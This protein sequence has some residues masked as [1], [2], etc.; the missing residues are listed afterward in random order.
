MKKFVALSATA[1]INHFNV[2][3]GVVSK[4]HAMPTSS[5]STEAQETVMIDVHQP[6]NGDDAPLDPQIHQHQSPDSH[7]GG[8]GEHQVGATWWQRQTSDVESYEKYSEEDQLSNPTTRNATTDSKVGSVESYEKQVAGG[9]GSEIEAISVTT[10]GDDELDAEVDDDDAGNA[11]AHD[12][13][14]KQLDDNNNDFDWNLNTNVAALR[15]K[16]SPEERVVH[17]DSIFFPT[18]R[19]DCNVFGCRKGAIDENSPAPTRIRSRQVGPVH[20]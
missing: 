8:T 4:S 5:S 14:D 13:T 18:S 17:G 10:E 11:D 15:H 19:S 7:G 6:I 12:G 3:G 2:C 1:F 16:D 9:E 20:P